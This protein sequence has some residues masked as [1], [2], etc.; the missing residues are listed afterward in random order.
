M[1]WLAGTHSPRRLGKGFDY[2]A[3][4]PCGGSWHRSVNPA[5][6]YRLDHPSSDLQLHSTKEFLQPKWEKN[7]MKWVLS[8]I[9]LLC[10][11]NF[12]GSRWG[13]VGVGE[14]TCFLIILS[15]E[16]RHGTKNMVHKI[17]RND[18]GA[19]K[20]RQWFNPWIVW[21]EQV[22]VSKEDAWLRRNVS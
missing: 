11:S 3:H 2:G 12:G 17:R 4:E 14:Q 16:L 6:D 10:A 18:L 7:K 9:A 1:S 13:G 21:C 8:F 5:R 22:P 15:W 19:K 20:E